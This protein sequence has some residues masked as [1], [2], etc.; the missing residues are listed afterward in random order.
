MEES[1]KK[2]LRTRNSK[3]RGRIRPVFEIPNMKRIIDGRNSDG[4]KRSFS[5][6]TLPPASRRRFAQTAALAH[7][8]KVN[9]RRR[10]QI[11]LK[12]FDDAKNPDHGRRI[13]DF[14]R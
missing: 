10:D 8:L 4:T 7:R 6:R 12:I 2:K 9:R 5:H 13:D 11:S 1:D 3:R 14:F